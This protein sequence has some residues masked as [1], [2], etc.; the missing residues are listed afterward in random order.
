MRYWKP[1]KTAL[2]K[3]SIRGLHMPDYCKTKSVQRK[4]VR[5]TCNAKTVRM[6]VGMLQL[7]R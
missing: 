2:N 6:L 5:R 4:L 1:P 7:L 3:L